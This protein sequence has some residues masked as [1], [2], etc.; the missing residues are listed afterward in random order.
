M[1]PAEYTDRLLS[2]AASDNARVVCEQL[3]TLKGLQGYN[4]KAAKVYLKLYE[5]KGTSNPASTDTPKKTLVIPASGAF[6]FDFPEG[7][8]FRAG[9]SLRL[10]A[11]I[12]DN[13]ATALVANDIEGLNVDFCR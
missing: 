2:A 9:M 11:A 13:D 3:C 4:N 10:T 6:V 7:I 1:R 8:Q 5:G 12:A